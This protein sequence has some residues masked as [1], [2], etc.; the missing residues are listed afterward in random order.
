MTWVPL[1][2]TSGRSTRWFVALK[3]RRWRVLNVETTTAGAAW[4][5]GDAASMPPSRTGSVARLMDPMCHRRVSLN[6]NPP[7][8]DG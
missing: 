2:L 3:M 1:G 4:A 6:T 5:G 7:W 8:D